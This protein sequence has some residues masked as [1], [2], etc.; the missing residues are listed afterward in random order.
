M[1]Y[2]SPLLARSRELAPRLLWLVA[3]TLYAIVVYRT[4]WASDDVFITLRSIDNF[5][6]GYGL[7]WNVAERVQVYTHPLW[8]MTL[9][10]AYAVTRE[11]YYTTIAVSFVC[12]F[13][14]FIVLMRLGTRRGLL[15]PILVFGLCVSRCYVD[16]STSGLENPLS[17][18]LAAL[19]FSVV[20]A[21][22]QDRNDRQRL[23][24]GALVAGLAVVNREDQSLLFAPALLWLALTSGTRLRS[25]L[26]TLS[27]AGAAPLA[28][29]VFALVYYGFPFPNTAYAKLNVEI[30]RMELFGR[31]LHYIGNF[32]RH[33]PPSALVI[34]AATALIVVR[35]RAIERAMLVGLWLY[36][37]YVASI[38]GDFMSGRFFSTPFLLSVLLLIA[39]APELKTVHQAA[40]VG[41]LTALSFV[42]AYPI[43]LSPKGLPA[44][45]DQV[46]D[47]GIVD[48]RLYYFLGAGLVNDKPTHKSR[49]WHWRAEKGLELRERP[50]AVVAW[51]AVGYTGYFAGPKVHFVDFWALCDPL[52]ARIPFRTQDTWRMGHFRRKI[53]DGYLEAV[54]KGDASLIEQPFLA[55][56]YGDLLKVTRAPLFDEARWKAIYRLNT[57]YYRAGLNAV[58]Y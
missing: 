22:S 40:Y 58:E 9:L 19:F 14:T 28:W 55:Q 47:E 57:G 48:E 34:A 41:V 25:V 4:A 56:V 12:S 30:G 13:A 37:A 8:M 24:Q 54:D 45:G 16:Y 10:A 23:Y 1:S 38:G 49:P 42:P 36:V 33:D 6:H 50:P 20:I 31:G 17:H 26:K 27:L 5:V 29:T 43:W 2:S 39:R 21:E 3:A 18:L 46:K 51:G 32:V 44:G 52:L 35:G 15:G 53:P 7:R 11:A